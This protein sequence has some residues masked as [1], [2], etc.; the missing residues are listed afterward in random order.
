MIASDDVLGKN[1]NMLKLEP[2]YE[3]SNILSNYSALLAGMKTDGS[4]DMAYQQL[5]NMINDK[6]VQRLLLE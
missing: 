6:E 2:S 1:G 3:G 4:M 5:G